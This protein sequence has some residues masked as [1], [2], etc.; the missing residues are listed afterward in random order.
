[1]VKPLT[2]KGDKPKKRK[3]HHDPDRGPRDVDNDVST[4]SSTSATKS[5]KRAEK[6]EAAAAETHD[7]DTSWVSADAAG[8]IN[9]PVMIVLPS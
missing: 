5:A 4:Q 7:E 1:M 2:F 6:D 8:D 3:R 9:G